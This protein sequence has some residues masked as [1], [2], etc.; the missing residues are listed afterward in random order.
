MAISR[1]GREHAGAFEN[2]VE[3]S[4]GTE[5][6]AHR[7]RGPCVTVERGCLFTNCPEVD[8]QS[9]AG[10]QHETQGRFDAAA[11]DDPTSTVRASTRF[12]ASNVAGAKLHTP[13]HPAR[14]ESRTREQ[15]DRSDSVLCGQNK[16]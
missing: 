1:H 6:G 8:Q 13:D 12:A 4:S 7:D 5:N 10:A 16:A 2:T 3:G 15:S 9:Q 14:A 11:D